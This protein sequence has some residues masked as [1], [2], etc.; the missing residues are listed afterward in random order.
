M[1]YNAYGKYSLLKCHNM[2]V[3]YVEYAVFTTADW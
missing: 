3:Q 1:I 2:Y